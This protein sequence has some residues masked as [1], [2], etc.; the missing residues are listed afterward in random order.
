[1]VLAIDGAGDR[2][3]G[4]LVICGLTINHC[5]STTTRM[6]GNLGFETY[7]VADACATMHG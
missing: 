6:A 4:A 3:A 5:V 1:M 2:V 7:L